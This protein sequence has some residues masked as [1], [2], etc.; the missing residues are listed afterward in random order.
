MKDLRKF[1]ATTI[2]EYLNENNQVKS[3]NNFEM[4]ELLKTLPFIKYVD[5][6]TGRF[7]HSIDLVIMNEDNIVDLKEI[8]NKNN[9][10][11]ERGRDRSF[12]ITQKYVDDAKVE[13]PKVLYHTTP[14]KNVESILKYGLK[15]KS[16]DLRH[17]YPPRIYVADDVKSLKPL[18]TEL[19]RWKGNED[20]SIIKIDTSGL[21]MELYIDSTSAYK[22]HYYIQGI[23]VIPSENIELLK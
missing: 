2:R 12:T 18:S 7:L 17:K 21:N 16:E 9:W 19:K 22:G 11:I 13:I 4:F 6:P 14:S 1:I 15:S 8:L 23:D 3:T 20:Y 10:Y 5:R